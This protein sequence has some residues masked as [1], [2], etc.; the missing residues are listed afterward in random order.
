MPTGGVHKEQ[1][2]LQL[3]PCLLKELMYIANIEDIA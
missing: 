1:S 3:V 2:L